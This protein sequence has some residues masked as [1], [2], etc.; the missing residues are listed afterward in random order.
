MPQVKATIDRMTLRRRHF[1]Q[2]IARLTFMG[3]NDTQISVA[4]GITKA[5]VTM[6]RQTPLYLSQWA[7]LTTGVITELDGGVRTH[8]ENFKEEI[9]AMVPTA[10]LAIQD[11]LH[12]KANPRI[13]FEAAK[14]ILDREGTTAVVSKSQVTHKGEINY[15]QHDL[16]GD[17]LLEALKSIGASQ[18]SEAPA[19][20]PGA[21]IFKNSSGNNS[22][23]QESMAAQINLDDF[24]VPKERPV[25]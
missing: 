6:N 10:L 18:E 9:T 19:P 13:R 17:N 3:L 11:A 15:E 2:Q 5:M 20:F 25:Q 8:T 7:E 14:Q 1:V 21:N 16:V 4:L 24:V 12:D 23:T 22:K